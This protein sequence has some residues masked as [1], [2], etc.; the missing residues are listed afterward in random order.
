MVTY[1]NRCFEMLSFDCECQTGD[2]QRNP[3]NHSISKSIFSNQSIG[4]DRYPLLHHRCL[5]LLVPSLVAGVVV[6]N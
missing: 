3:I 2:I 4:K 5:I 6:R 1:K